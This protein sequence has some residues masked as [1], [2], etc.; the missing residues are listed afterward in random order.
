MTRSSADALVCWTCFL[1]SCLIMFVHGVCAQSFVEA[2]W[3]DS[4]ECFRPPTFVTDL[5]QN[6]SSRH[7]G[8]PEGILQ[9]GGE[10]PSFEAGAPM[11]LLIPRQEIDSQGFGTGSLGS[12]GP[13]SP[14]PRSSRPRHERLIQLI[15]IAC[16]MP[17]LCIVTEVGAWDGLGVVGGYGKRY[18]PLGHY[19]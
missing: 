3:C 7:V 5:F 16:E 15:G 8:A 11:R 18:R 17:L 14:H 13:R 6:T 2:W 12:I 10:P 4:I 1:C 9:G 19:S